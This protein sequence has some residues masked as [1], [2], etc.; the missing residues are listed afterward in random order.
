MRRKSGYHWILAR[1]CDVLEIGSYP[2]AAVNA[3]SVGNDT[4][5][6]VKVG[7]NVKVTLY[8]NDLPGTGPGDW[9]PLITSRSVVSD[10]NDTTSAI[11]VESRFNCPAPGPSQVVVAA[12]FNFSGHCDVLDF[13]FP[14]TYAKIL[15]LSVGND[16]VSSVVCGSSSSLLLWEPT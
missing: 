8:E 9:M 1:N 4:I 16:E 15:G 6:S 12:G 2:Y 5:S 11:R 7:S 13:G 14:V 10:F 3:M